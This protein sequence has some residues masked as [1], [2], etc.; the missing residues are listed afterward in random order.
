MA[1]G[2]TRISH[3]DFDAAGFRWRIVFERYTQALAESHRAG[4]K[5]LSPA[6]REQN[7]Q[8]RRRCEFSLRVKD[9][10]FFGPCVLGWYRNGVCVRNTRF[11]VIRTVI[12]DLDVAPVLVEAAKHYATA[13]DK[14]EAYSCL[15]GSA[16]ELRR[17]LGL[18]NTKPIKIERDDDDDSD[19]E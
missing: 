7:M 5:Q 8:S 6:E 17:K 14:T 16:D 2:N 3:A 19:S 13:E 1:S 18:R 4:Y 12:G 11:A 10:R 15:G 9:G